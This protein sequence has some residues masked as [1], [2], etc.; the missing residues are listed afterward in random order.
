MAKGF[1]N[2]KINKEVVEK[3]RK[4][5]EK[6]GVPISVFFEKA[7]EEKLKSKDKK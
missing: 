2:V 7:A 3:V 1:E 4:D 5:K 6:T